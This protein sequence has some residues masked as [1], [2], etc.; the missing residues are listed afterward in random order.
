MFYETVFMVN[1]NC[2][3]FVN[4]F[5]EHERFDEFYHANISL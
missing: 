3:V 4:N 1:W 2:L 5:K